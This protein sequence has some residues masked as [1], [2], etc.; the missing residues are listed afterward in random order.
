MKKLFIVA[1]VV[2]AI[3]VFSFVFASTKGSGQINSLAPEID[4]IACQTEMS[5][6]HFHAHLSII[7][8]GVPLTVPSDI[9][10]LED[11]NC[12]Y[13]LHTHDET[14]IIH[15]ESPSKADFTLGQF[16]DIWGKPLNETQA[17]YYLNGKLW[18]GDPKNIPLTA[19]G[20]ITIEEGREV[21]PPNFSFP[22]GL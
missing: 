8:D 17:R 6:I 7:K 20:L 19:H 1:V 14:G 15:I 16:F 9:G 2:G 21:P 12:L 5:K 22:A 11:K 4:G 13:W 18:E 10:I 3:G